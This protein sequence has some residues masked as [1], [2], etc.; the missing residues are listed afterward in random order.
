MNKAR[1]T[2]IFDGESATA[3]T[4]HRSFIAAGKQNN[5]D[6]QRLRALVNILNMRIELL[7]GELAAFRKSIDTSDS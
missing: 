1:A 3:T 4:E 5:A 2:K 6:V 7:E